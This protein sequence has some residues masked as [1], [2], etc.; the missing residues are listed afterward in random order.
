MTQSDFLHTPSDA[1]AIYQLK[2]GDSTRNLCFEPLSRLQQT[3]ETV[4]RANYQ[5]VY[6]APLPVNAPKA[7]MEQLHAL[8]EQFNIAHP[9]D[10]TG[11]SLSVSDVMALKQDGQISCYY[12]DRW[13]FEKLPNFLP[14]AMKKRQEKPTVAEL[15]KPKL[16]NRKPANQLHKK[17]IGRDTER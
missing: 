6:T 10:F 12:V 8:Y 13:S 14:A 11:H 2:D 4:D 9:A 15:L 16:H 7:P 1:F 3:G 17:N 5:C